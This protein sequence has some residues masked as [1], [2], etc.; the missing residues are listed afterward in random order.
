MH[1]QFRLLFG[2]TSVAATAEET[3]DG[4]RLEHDL[5]K[6]LNN[7]AVTKIYCWWVQDCWPTR[8]GESS[9][10]T[11]S[12][13]NW[14]REPSGRST[15]AAISATDLKLPS[16]YKAQQSRDPSSSSRANSS[17][18]WPNPRKLA[19]RSTS[20]TF[21]ISARKVIATSWLWISLVTPFKICSIYAR[22]NFH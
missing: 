8:E 7:N 15:S 11:T 13:R 2:R 6:F 18:I 21:S 1:F 3:P 20:P 19:S 9:G 16:K 22:G 4:V 14:A 5:T 10:T 17:L 12:L